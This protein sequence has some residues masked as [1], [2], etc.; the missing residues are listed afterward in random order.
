MNKR[1]VL[2]LEKARAKA[3]KKQ[4]ATNRKST[5]ITKGDTASERRAKR[6]A[7]KLDLEKRIKEATS[8]EDTEQLNKELKGVNEGI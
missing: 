4:D 3:R 2:N 5:A 6:V 8:L 1:R 7:L